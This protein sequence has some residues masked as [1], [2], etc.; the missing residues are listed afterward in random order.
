MAHPPTSV[1]PVD[2]RG[3]DE[4]LR[5]VTIDA[6]QVAAV[7]SAIVF[8][9]VPAERLVHDGQAL[10]ARLERH[11]PVRA[12]GHDVRHGFRLV[13]DHQRGHAHRRGRR[14]HQHH[15][16][17][18]HHGHLTLGAVRGRAVKPAH[19]AAVGEPEQRARARG[20]RLLDRQRVDLQDE[21]RLQCY[22]ITVLDSKGVL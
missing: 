4:R 19:G 10:Q 22:R 3:V 5:A 18:G 17:R 1:S 8:R 11:R 21:R 13:R 16:R 6:D 15:V 2:Q 12:L 7:L 9:L 14:L 20:G